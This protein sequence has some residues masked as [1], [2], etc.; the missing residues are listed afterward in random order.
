MESRSCSQETREQPG[1][2][3]CLHMSPVPGDK[4]PETPPAGS[5][6]ALHEQG[7]PGVMGLGQQLRLRQAPPGTF[8]FKGKA[9]G[10][11]MVNELPRGEANI[12]QSLRTMGIRL[13]DD[14]YNGK[15]ANM[16]LI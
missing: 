14:S 11:C 8:W 15:L 1:A 12:Q 16:I 5:G 10:N 13:T 6:L 9:P 4:A 3:S 2:L 7:E